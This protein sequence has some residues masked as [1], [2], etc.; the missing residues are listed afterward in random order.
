VYS[1]SVLARNAQSALVL[2]ER[3]VHIPEQAC[4]AG[5]LG[6]FCGDLGVR[7]HFGQREMPKDEPDAPTEGQLNLTDDG[8]CQRSM[9]AFIV[10]V[11]N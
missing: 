6:A 2:K 5:E 11:F 3:I 7:V 4:C 10:A 9:R 8:I 1:I